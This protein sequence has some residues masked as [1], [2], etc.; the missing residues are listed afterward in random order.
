[1]YGSIAQDSAVGGVLDEG[2]LCLLQGLPVEK[3]VAASTQMLPNILSTI[4]Y[5][6]T[7]NGGK[8]GMR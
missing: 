1:M 2:V 4:L 5:R 3:W 8:G 7:Q 6:P